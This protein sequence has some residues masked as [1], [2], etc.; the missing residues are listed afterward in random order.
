[1]DTAAGLIHLQPRRLRRSQIGE[2]FLTVFHA[3]CQRRTGDSQLPED[4]FG[5]AVRHAPHSARAETPSEG[6]GS[7][8]VRGV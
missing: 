1:M 6:S 2:E 7:G 4:G 5:Y 8:G 3:T